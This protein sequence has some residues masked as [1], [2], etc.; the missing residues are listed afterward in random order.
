M[1]G[2]VAD[3]SAP[4]NR[5]TPDRRV[6]GICANFE[7]PKFVAQ[8]SDWHELLIQTFLAT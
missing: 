8:R 6:F 7:A 5:P 4:N 3:S 1:A 2:I